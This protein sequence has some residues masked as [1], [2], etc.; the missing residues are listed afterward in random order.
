MLTRDAD[1]T[2][3][4]PDRSSRTQV[5]PDESA[6]LRTPQGLRVDIEVER[7]GQRRITPIPHRGRRR[8]DTPV[9]AVDR[10]APHPRGRVEVR[11]GQEPDRCGRG[12]HRQRG[13]ILR[14][15]AGGYPRSS[16]VISAGAGSTPAGP[17]ST[18]SADS[19]DST[20]PA[21]LSVG[22]GSK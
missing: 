15:V 20:E 3:R 5:V 21:A 14:I 2:G 18:S 13:V 22:S 4:R 16:A 1:D 11:Q 10:Y 19:T 8:Q 7:T 12:T 6:H 17:G 9:P